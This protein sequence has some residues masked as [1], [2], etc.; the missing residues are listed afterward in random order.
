MTRERTPYTHVYI[1]TQRERTVL[2]TLKKGGRG[3]M[4]WAK[5]RN[6]FEPQRREIETELGCVC[7]C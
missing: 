4:G 5:R 1:H 7:C 2:Y 3:R 6:R